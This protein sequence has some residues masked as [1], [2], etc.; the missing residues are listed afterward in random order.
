MPDSGGMA[1]CFVSFR[2]LDGVRHAVE[3]QAEVCMKAAVLGL[4]VFKKHDLES[5]PQRTPS[6]GVEVRSSG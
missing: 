2:D 5:W 3:V 4:A 1:T 6:V